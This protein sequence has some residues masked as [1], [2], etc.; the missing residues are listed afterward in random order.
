MGGFAAPFG[1]GTLNVA[2]AN[3]AKSYKNNALMGDL[4][5]PRCP[6]D[7]Q[8][9]QYVVHDRSAM[10]LDA[11]TL[12][13]P[14]DAP[15]QI[16]SAFSTAPYFCKAHALQAKVPFE[17]EQYGLGF[18][19]SQI[20][21]GTENIM[22]KLLLDREVNL[23]NL[24]TNPANVAN[25]LALAGASM[26]DSYLTGGVSQPVEAIEAAKAMVRQSGVVANLL[27]L[28][29]P[30]F[31]ALKS[32]PII[33]EYFKYTQT[34]AITLDNLSNVFGIRT[35]V[36]SAVSVDK[37]DIVSF[38]WGQTAV[39]A[40][41]QDV[42]DQTDLSALKTF[43]WT[44]APQTVDGYGVIVEPQYPLSSKTT[45][46]SSDWYWDIRITAP[47]TLYTFTNVCAAPAMAAIPAPVAGY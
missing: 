23:A 9:F 13:A 43:V 37:N 36:A 18:N 39:L 3:I 12:R 2:A 4:L 21:K 26:W 17:T 33:I 8:S 14:G 19:F 22:E 32:N 29:D 27:I 16:R 34:G 15:Q 7:R 41:V 42:A 40:Y 10:R 28:S 38:V 5:A 46:V 31:V 6:M 20:A 35:V 25:T 45:L 11:A 47:E 24:V 30:A 1:G 44:G